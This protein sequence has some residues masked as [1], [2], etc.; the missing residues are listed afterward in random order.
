MKKNLQLKGAIALNDFTINGLAHVVGVHP[1]T[2]QRAVNGKSDLTVSKALSVAQA[3]NS[4][5]E[6]LF[7]VGGDSHE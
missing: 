4:T 2:L 3:L 7:S 1:N 6:G 5:V